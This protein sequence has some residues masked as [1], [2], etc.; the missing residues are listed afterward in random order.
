MIVYWK[1]NYFYESIESR[2]CETFLSNDVSVFLPMTTGG[3]HGASKDTESLV[4][5]YKTSIY[6][7]IFEK[8][9]HLFLKCKNSIG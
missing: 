4:L 2:S 9:I 8:F 5:F 6:H 3:V 7:F 1:K